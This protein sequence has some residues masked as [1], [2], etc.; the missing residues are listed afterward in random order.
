MLERQS[1]GS[2]AFMS[3]TCAACAQE[4]ATKWA[5]SSHLDLSEVRADAE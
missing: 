5:V 3:V 1:A 2:F 4:A